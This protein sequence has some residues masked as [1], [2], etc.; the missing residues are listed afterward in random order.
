[1]SDNTPIRI[2]IDGTIARLVIDRPPL[3]I[4]DIATMQ[5]M[6]EQLR[7]L[8]VRQ[9]ITALVITTR[10]RMFSAG[11]DIPEHQAETIDEMLRV[12]HSLFE[13]L[14]EFPVPTVCAVQ[15][16]ALGGGMEL[17][18]FCDFTLASEDA[19]FGLPE[20]SLGVFPPVAVAYLHRLIGIKA[21]TELICTGRIIGAAEAHALGMVNQVYQSERLT[22]GI[23]LFL[24]P[25]RLLS[26]FALTQTKA[27]LRAAAH[28]DFLSALRD[29]ESVYRGSLM[30]GR[31]PHE[32]IRAFMEKRA[33]RWSHA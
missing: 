7:E 2:T 26:G 29:A 15:G 33:P 3:N 31:D 17:A 12:V 27:A 14:H 11:V 28:S 13:T 10:G 20:I 1:M 6:T 32:G 25:F 8:R 9:D 4:L 16:D 24:E 23:D 30:A 5:R 19:R 18:V 22:E 21:A